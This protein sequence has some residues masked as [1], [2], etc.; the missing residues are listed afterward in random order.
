M[1]RKQIDIAK[2]YTSDGSPVRI[3]CIDGPDSNYPVLGIVE[4]VSGV[5]SWSSTG[6]TPNFFDVELSSVW[7][8]IE[9][10]E[11]QV[12]YVNIY[13][14]RGVTSKYRDPGE[15][16]YTYKNRHDADIN[17]QP[18]RLACIR[19]EYEEGEGLE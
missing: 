9:V 16:L 15:D 8:L 3:L 4:G 1:K 18:T 11:K 14:N 12:R 6:L 2:K 10:K 17:A 7:D 13:I 19:I 5:K